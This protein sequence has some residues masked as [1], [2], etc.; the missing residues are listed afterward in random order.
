MRPRTITLIVFASLLLVT[1]PTLASDDPKPAVVMNEICWAGAVWDHT[2]EW[3]ELFN[4]TDLPIDL[5][6]WQLISSDGAPCIRLH[7]VIQPQTDDVAASG[8]FLLERGSDESVPGIAADL[9]YQGALTNSG[10]IL[11]LIDS[12]GR[13]IDS[14]NASLSADS[15]LSWPAGSDNRGVLPFASME[16]VRFQLGDEPSNW[17]SCVADVP[18]DSARRILGTPKA[19]NSVYNVLPIVQLTITPAV[20]HPGVPAEFDAKG[21]TDPNDPIVSYHWEFGDGT[22]ATGS[23]ATHTYPDPGE[24]TITLILTD[25]KGGQTRLTRDVHVAPLTAPPIADFSLVLKPDCELARAG[26]LLAFQDESSDVDSEIISWKWHFGDGNEAAGQRATHSY[27]DYGEYVIE[28]RVTNTQG[29]MGIQTR[30]LSIASRLPVVAFTFSPERPNQFESVRFDASESFDP[31]GEIV[32]YQWDF[33]GDGVMDTETSGP[34]AVHEFDSA[35]R[36]TLRI[37]AVDDLSQRAMRERTI[38]VNAVPVAQFQISSFE[39]R[40]LELVTLTDLSH[41]SDGTIVQWSWDFGDGTISDEVSPSH[42]YQQNGAMEIILTVTDELGATDT[43]IASINVGN[44]PPVATLTVAEATR[45]TDGTF[46]FDAFGSFDPSPQ[47]SLTRFEWSLD[48]GDEFELETS[49][50]TLAHAFAED[51]HYTVRV[52]V[53]DSDGA[54]VASEPLS[55]TVT[56]RSPTVSRV[57]WSPNNPSDV[58][59]V[60]FTAHA[61]DPDGEITGWTWT[62]ESGAM[63]SSQE[64]AHAFEDDGSYL[65]SIQVRDNDGASS[66]TYSVTVPIRNTPPVAEFTAFQVSTC[67]VGGMQFDASESYDPTPTGRIVHVAWDFGDGTSCPGNSAGCS[68]RERTTPEHC[69]SEPGT[70]I[71]TLVV[72][73][74]H[75]AMSSIQKSI[76]INE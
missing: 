40:E 38:D 73:D 71:V 18:A 57:T 22:E 9:V 28:L 51:G 15:P 60:V 26:D 65:L 64:F 53:T 31:D 13:V 5:E 42:C 69:Y 33:D 39:P 43:A 58:D 68:D 35:G 20:P 49:V 41:D 46:F 74:E 48:G 70:Y 17:A 4:T 24:Y 2:A 16:R 44:L 54:T 8:Y 66:N 10:E 59:D 30:S 76:L 6:G 12:S 50:P 47:G 34:I 3:I 11:A 52:R 7:S 61:S 32:S 25:S 62:L 45:P 36:F 14:V 21:S 72:I 37:H 27:Q 1:I 23:V 55:I 75:G 63:G 19:E 67:G 29:E 56:N